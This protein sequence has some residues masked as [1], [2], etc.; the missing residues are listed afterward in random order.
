MDDVR[1]VTETEYQEACR[2]ARFRVLFD[3]DPRVRAAR[4]AYKKAEV[5]AGGREAGAWDTANAMF[6]T[7]RRELR[8][9]LAGETY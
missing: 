1:E 4:K 6:E 8:A 2:Q 9:K 7:V 3:R 5:R